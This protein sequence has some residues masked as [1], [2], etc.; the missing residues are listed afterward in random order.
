MPQ[1]GRHPPEMLVCVV[2]LKSYMKINNFKVFCLFIFACAAIS[3]KERWNDDRTNLK[4]SY[5][6]FRD[7]NCSYFYILEA[8]LFILALQA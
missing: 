2:D 6:L 1:Y 5:V 4:L 8:Q 3:K 7:T